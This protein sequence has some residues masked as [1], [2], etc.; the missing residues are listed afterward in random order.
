MIW[1]TLSISIL[2]KR[3]KCA[4]ERTLRL[5][6]GNFQEMSCAIHGSNQPSYW[7]PGI[8]MQL[9]RKDLYTTFLSDCFGL[10]WI[11]QEKEKIWKFYTKRN[12]TILGGK[13]QSQSEGRKKDSETRAMHVQAWS[14]VDCRGWDQPPHMLV[15]L[16]IRAAITV[17]PEDRVPRQRCLLYGPET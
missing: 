8:E 9:H 1:K 16:K 7:K 3:R 10:S 17:I 13:E 11:A 4:L 14:V 15:D 12:V 2:Q 6:L 5:R